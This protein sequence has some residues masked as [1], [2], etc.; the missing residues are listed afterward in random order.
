MRDYEKLGAFYLG[1]RWDAA[2]QQTVGEPLL[3]DA[4]DLATHAVCVGMTGGGKTG[5]G[6]TLIEEAAIGGIPIIAIDPKGDLGNLLLTFPSL[7]GR[8]SA[9]DRRGRCGT[10]WPHTRR[11]RQLDG[12]VVAGWFQELGAER[13]FRARCGRAIPPRLVVRP[14]RR[15]V[16]AVSERPSG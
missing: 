14:P 5:L 4:K 15:P 1:R 7:P 16:G 8:L 3:Y 13:Q 6:V 9:L 12:G 2:G 10:T 11:A